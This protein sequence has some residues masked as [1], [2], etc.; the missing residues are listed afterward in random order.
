MLDQEP[1]QIE[2]DI[3]HGDD[4]VYQFLPV[5]VSVVK[6]V[7]TGQYSLPDDTSKED[8]KGMIAK[9][10]MKSESEF[11]WQ[12]WL[13]WKSSG[14]QVKSNEANSIANK[15]SGVENKFEFAKEI[16]EYGKYWSLKYKGKN[17]ATPKLCEIIDGVLGFLATQAES[18]MAGKSEEEC[19]QLTKTF[20]G[21]VKE[22]KATVEAYKITNFK[23]TLEKSS[24]TEIGLRNPY[25]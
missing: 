14:D 11:D 7:L 19:A 24:D 4:F 9:Y 10:E 25:G 20:I 21:Y 12:K 15:F 22:I 23:N 13:D 2:A 8:I 5:Q 18:Q 16:G 3:Q 1:S 6:Q 17:F